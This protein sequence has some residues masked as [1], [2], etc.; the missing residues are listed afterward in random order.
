M[1]SSF[2]RCTAS[3]SCLILI[4]CIFC[5]PIAWCLFKYL[6]PSQL[7][8][9]PFYQ[10]FTHD[11]LYHVHTNLGTS[12]LKLKNA[13][14]VYRACPRSSDRR[15]DRHSED[16]RASGSPGRANIWNSLPTRQLPPCRCPEAGQ[17]VW[18]SEWAQ[19]CCFCEYFRIR[20]RH[21]DRPADRHDVSSILHT[22][23]KI[24][25]SDGKAMFNSELFTVDASPRDTSCKSRKKAI[26]TA[27]KLL[28]VPHSC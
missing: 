21:L 27:L 10:S 4:H 7:L 3:G 12:S 2:N 6:L 28:L 24:I 5:G 1:T 13:Y 19:A 15:L 23:H 16:Q 26:A 22:F 18:K 17:E 8:Y 9:L 11:S 14:R 25:S 20:Q